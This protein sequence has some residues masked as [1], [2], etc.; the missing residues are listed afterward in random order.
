MTE[1][2][3]SS[4]NNIKCMAWLGS[5][6]WDASNWKQMLQNS[7]FDMRNFKFEITWMQLSSSYLNMFKDL[8]RKLETLQVCTKKC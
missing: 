8:H 7:N 1:A 4:Q 2:S 6:Q 3:S 5:M